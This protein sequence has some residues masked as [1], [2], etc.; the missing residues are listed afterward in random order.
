[1][2]FGA[3]E[4]GQAVQVGAVLV[5]AMLIVSLSVY[6][7]FI[8]PDQNAQ[9]EFDHNADVQRQ[10]ETLRDAIVSAPDARG[11]R[12]VVV[13]LGTTY[14]SRT[15]AINPPHPRG[16]LR[17]AG[18]SNEA[19]NIS[20]RNA[21]A[22]G[23]TGDFWNG[24]AHNYSTG[25]IV[26]SPSYNE[27]QRPPTT[28][29][30]NSVLYNRF[31]VENLT[32]TGQAFV[33]GRRIRLVALDGSYAR[34]TEG[35]VTLDV[36]RVSSSTNTVTVT[37]ASASENVTVVV[38]TTLS[39]STW[40]ND[41]LVKEFTA[42]GGYVRRVWTTPLPGEPGRL[43][44]VELKPET[45]YRLR[46][47]KV[48]IGRNVR[49]EPAAY[50]TDIEG[51]ATTLAEGS[52]RRLV[53]EARDRYDN[54]VGGVRVKANT[55]RTDSALRYVG[56]NETGP[57]GRVTMVYEAPADVDGGPASDRANVS[58]AAG[59]RKRVLGSFDATTAKNVSMELA[60][61][62]TDASG[63]GG[64]GGGTSVAYTLAWQDPS[65]QPGVECPNGVTGTCTVFANETDLAELTVETSPTADSA[66]VEYVRNDTS[67]ARVTPA[68]GV[69]YD[70]TDTT[71][72]EPLANGS[73]KLLAFSG[74]DQAVLDVEVVGY[75]PDPVAETGRVTTTATGWQT[76][77]LNNSYDD[78]VVVARPLSFDDTEPL[79]V[80]VDSVTGSSFR[81][82]IDEFDNDNENDG[83]QAVTFH[84]LAIE[85]G[86][87]EL[88]NGTIVEA[89]ENSLQ[90]NWK[91]VT[92]D[93]PF[94]D[95]PFVFSESQTVNGGQPVI[96]RQRNVD[97]TSFEHRLQEGEGYDDN[98]A[99]EAVGWVAVQNTS[100]TTGATTFESGNITGV[101]GVDDNG[102][103]TISFTETYAEP[104][105]AFAQ[106]QTY[107]G[108]NTAWE[109]YRQ[110]TSGSVDVV[111]DEEQTSDAERNHIP[112]E[113]GYL[114]VGSPGEL[115][116]VSETDA[117]SVSGQPEAT[118]AGNQ[119]VT[120]ALANDRTIGANL[121]AIAV[122]D[123]TAGATEVTDTTTVTTNRTGN[124]ESST[125]TVGG[126]A[127]T[128]DQRVPIPSGGA[129]S[130]TLGDFSDGSTLDMTREEVRLTLYFDDGSERT[131]ILTAQ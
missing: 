72:F 17:T 7:A 100:G 41:L 61:I 8:V 62:N 36:R 130:I 20:V 54:P 58:I 1:V 3:D 31:E 78:P 24:T 44:H 82:R 126:S 111:I 121:T 55:S 89:G 18:T 11:V 51:N 124:T 125:I 113:F 29:Y 102:W 129:T 112:N 70:G 33:D 56:D 90:E 71:L 12:P 91:T 21:T 57:D 45:T 19:V 81:Y 94:A 74:G 46:L 65:S 50:L 97:A 83:H 15:V 87:H 37:N 40:R 4:R 52:E 110:L 75:D 88:E 69:T 9:V 93:Y 16:S 26:Y 99:V 48:G 109:R 86:T 73:V 115:L 63:T 104:P 92:Y 80:R 32:T 127:E 25:R 35:S 38:P 116:D 42:Q 10:L 66:G 30:E 105:R 28:V 22:E 60:V 95:P 67:V 14:S 120:F 128:L 131:V 103:G 23:E 59:P 108:G 53:V 118:G 85:T 5:L 106:M 49:S 98:H 101:Q 13:R 84:Y 122:D 76:V 123:T 39:E 117:V 77:T 34:T 43:L 119:E 27:Y 47:A 68:D 79:Y 2:P 114:V 64:G 107:N 96:E 6:Q